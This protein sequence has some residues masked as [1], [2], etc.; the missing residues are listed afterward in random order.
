M[1]ATT[2]RSFSVLMLLAWILNQAHAQQVDSG[3]EASALSTA[4]TYLTDKVLTQNK[5]SFVDLYKQWLAPLMPGRSGL[6]MEALSAAAIKDGFQRWCNLRDAAYFDL[7]TIYGNTYTCR[8]PNGALFA[9]L[10]V[11]RWEG[12]KLGVGYDT[13]ETIALRE[14]KKADFERLK[15]INGPTGWI[16]TSEGRFKFLR[17]G[18]PERRYVI[19]VNEYDQPEVPIEQ[20]SRIDFKD[21]CCDIV[22]TKRDGSSRAMNIGALSRMFSVNSFTSFG[23][24]DCTDGLPFV[25]DTNDFG[26]QVQIFSVQ[27]G[28]KSIEID[29]N[30]SN[31]KQVPGGP[32]SVPF[33]EKKCEVNLVGGPKR[34]SLRQAAPKDET[35]SGTGIFVSTQGHLLTN[36]HVVGSCKSILVRTIGGANVPAL[37]VGRDKVNDLALLKTQRPVKNIASFRKQP[38]VIGEKAYAFGFPLTGLLSSEG[39]AS[40]GL[41]SALAGIEDDSRLLQ[42]STPVQPG[43]SGGP[44]YDS[45]GA[46]IGIVVSKLNALALMRATG[47][48]AQNVNFA[49][50]ESVAEGFM[51]TFGVGVRSSIPTK[52]KDPV[53]IFSK[54]R[55]ETAFVHCAH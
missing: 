11:E 24:I 53:S 23:G 25:V 7:K 45:R 3:A 28:L 12:G 39:N 4:N 34:P 10:R 37:L 2:I 19:S 52:P 47:D 40:E 41:V 35:M 30:E 43:N 44:L 15:A 33:D 5:G 51:A 27:K 55:N 50:K 38:A 22:V 26:P 18:L 42:M 6:K 8:E 32:M 13:P 14:K 1:Q 48:I 36:D 17:I 20:V 21:P 46:V 16:N 49:I 29:P 9:E 31:W 54:A